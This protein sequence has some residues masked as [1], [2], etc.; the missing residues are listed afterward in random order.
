MPLRLQSKNNKKEDI[1]YI[2]KEIFLIHEK[3]GNPAICGNIGGLRGH[4]TKWNKPGRERQILC[5]TTYTWEYW[6]ES[7]I[8]T[9]RRTVVSRV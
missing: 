2:F 5:S 9:E 8:E 1:V 4:Y 6:K 7:N 3:K